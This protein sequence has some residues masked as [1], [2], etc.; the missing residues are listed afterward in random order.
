MKNKKPKIGDK[1]TFPA[2]GNRT[3]NGIIIDPKTLGVTHRVMAFYEREN[4]TLVQAIVNGMG[5]NAFWINYKQ[6]TVVEE[7]KQSEK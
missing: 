2:S 3:G 4:K 6:L 5:A 1:V 7:V